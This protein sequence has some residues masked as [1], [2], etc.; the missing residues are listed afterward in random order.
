MRPQVQSGRLGRIEAGA[1]N[2][3]KVI[4]VD[5]RRIPEAEIA[6]IWLPIRPGTDVA[7]MLGWIRIIIEEGLYDADF[8]ERWT[9]GFEEL[10]TA[11]ADYTP[12][13]GRHYLA[14]G[15]YR[16]FGQ[17]VCEHQTGHA[18]QGLVRTSRA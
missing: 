10:K 4:V 7:L 13:R 14:S 17:A 2:G 5:P 11:A 3:A 9:V 16:R 18:R 8:V 1:K 12:E 15:G 6:D